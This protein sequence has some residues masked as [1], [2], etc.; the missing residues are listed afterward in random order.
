MNS[1]FN[2]LKSH[3]RSAILLF[4]LLLFSSENVLYSQLSVS[5]TPDSNHI[6]IGDYLGVKFAAKFHKNTA[7][8]FPVFK[9]TLASL[10]IISTDKKDTASIGDEIII[11]QRLIVSA[12][13]S[14]TYT[15]P[16]QAVF[17]TQNNLNDTAFTDEFVVSVSTVAIDTTQNFK[18]I[19]APLAVKRDWKEFALYIALVLLGILLAVAVW[20]LFKKYYKKKDTTKEIINKKKVAHEWALREL[21]KL[22][23]EKQWQKGNVK[24]YYSRLSDI[25][26]K[27]LEQRYSIFAMESTTDE[28]LLKLERDD[29][30][31]TAKPELRDIL[32]LSDLV[33]FAKQ[34][35]LPE[36]HKGAL[37]V[38]RA[39]IKST[40]WK[41]EINN[42]KQ[43]NSTE[44]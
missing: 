44:K 1:L 4:C 35:P 41:E 25:F 6:V 38:T 14:G 22:E 10:D 2:F 40:A 17:Y 42:Q 3:Q 37:N 33:K 18:P 23:Q 26:R 32:N 8:Q 19:K 30:P 31:E 16:A 20:W 15:I 7:I 36:Q 13:D 9:D 39:F 28:I 29:I 43:N 11:S 12:Y 24:L 5:F 27:Y 34:Q 21:Q